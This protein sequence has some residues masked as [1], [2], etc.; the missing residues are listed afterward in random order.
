MEVERLVCE[1]FERD[2]D[3][4]RMGDEERAEDSE[5]D[6]EVRSK[7]WTRFTEGDCS[8]LMGFLFCGVETTS[9]DATAR[10]SG[11]DGGRLVLLSL[12]LGV[13]GGMTA[14]YRAA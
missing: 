12:R 13:L 14:L 10:G 8:C 3:A 9:T 4:D 5:E 1:V 6:D 2:E 11:L 7:V